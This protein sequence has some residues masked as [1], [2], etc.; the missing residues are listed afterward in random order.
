MKPEIRNT[1][2]EKQDAWHD[3]FIKFFEAFVANLKQMADLLYKKT[4]D[5]HASVERLRKKFPAPDPFW[6][7]LIRVG[8][9]DLDVRLMITDYASAS[10]LKRLPGPVQT[11][12]L[13]ESTLSVVVREGADA[14]V[15][16]KPV[17]EMTH[18]EA[19]QATCSTGMVPIETQKDRVIGKVFSIPPGKPAE[20]YVITD[21]GKILIRGIEFDPV[22]LS[23]IAE[24]GKQ[25]RMAFLEQDLKKNQVKKGKTA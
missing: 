23:E 9:G 15:K 10:V 7:D 16:N 18:E 21:E 25:K 19:L 14:V 13:N 2:I 11:M 22:Q 3:Q 20:N 5:D 1:Q 4:C 12:L 17:Q 6:A 8:R 24:R